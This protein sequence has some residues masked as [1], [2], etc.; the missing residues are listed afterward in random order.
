M[1]ALKKRRS[2]PLKPLQPDDD[3]KPP[4]FSVCDIE[5]ADWIK[6]LV[7]GLCFK[8]FDE[9][10][11]ES[12]RMYQ[13]FLTLTEF[14]DYLFDPVFHP[15]DIVFAH[16]G[17]KYDF[18]F[19]LREAF[20][21]PEKYHIHDMIPRG[22]GL[23]CMSV[24]TF[25]IEEGTSKA[26]TDKDILKRLPDGRW[27][28]AT[29]TIVFRDC[30]A[31]L[32]ASLAS[33]TE[34]FGVEHKKQEID[35]A[36]IKEVTDELLEYL[37]YDC[38]GLYEVIEK[39]FNWPMIKRAGAAFT[40]ASQSLRVFRTFLQNPISSL[41]NEVDH[42]VRRSYFG[43]RT[44][45]FK[46]FFQQSRDNEILRSLD[47]N[48]L[49]PYIMRTLEYPGK[50]KKE[51]CFY[52]EKAIG[53]YDVE[54]EVPDMYIPPLGMRFEGMDHRLI[55]PTGKFRGIWATSEIN[56]A[57]EMGCKI[58]KVFNGMVFQNEGKI[59]E[60]FI[61]YLYAMRKRSVKGS[62]ENVLC[63]LIMNSTYGRF[64]L[65]TA[66][67]KLDFDRGQLYVDS[68]MDIPLDAEGKRII[69]LVKEPVDLSS[70]FTNVA[71]PAWVTAGSRIHMHKLIMKKP[72]DMY[73]MDTDSLKTTHDY[74]HN[75]SEL[76]ALKLEYKMK[77]A[78]FILPKTYMEDTMSPI[79][80]MFGL[81]GKEIK[82]EKTSKKLV[83]KGF[84]KKKIQAFT[85]D[86]F[87]S[88]LEGDMMRL[89]SLNP[90]KFATLRT[91]ISRKDFLVLLDEKPRQIRT[92]Y[93]KRRIV[94]RAWRQVYDTEPLHI[95][96]GEIKNLDKA[97]LKK[98]KPPTD[99]DYRRIEMEVAR[100]EGWL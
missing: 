11:R 60:G 55:F 91:A 40:I 43:G 5:A 15:H 69:R 49:Y 46:P 51:T 45:I 90:K 77:Q 71:I 80:K 88:A 68:H 42:F 27:M 19:I 35:Y 86:D 84:D 39:Y 36:K 95:K 83:M 6:F 87:T 94:K 8:F 12:S 31:M 25:T 28:I 17:G 78:A 73:Y 82:G 7:I 34:D 76:G 100:A 22:S 18:S 67:E 99:E 53:F 47:V 24:S 85:F 59:F 14:L 79:F 57:M 54:V 23:L 92:R 3:K 10:G 64:G 66:R 74:E 81:D 96:D 20:F 65:N 38:W 44:E 93:N 26:K 58:T 75:D 2:P 70:S 13:Y 50:F 33:L 30:S 72:E 1:S 63:K 21:D 97:I 56:Y 37:E 52:N 41:P 61:E 29:R 16:F 4:R 32:P 98:W 89:R 62:V 48:S 9:E